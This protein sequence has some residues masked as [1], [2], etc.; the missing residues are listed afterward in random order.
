MEG[1]EYDGLTGVTLTQVGYSGGASSD[2]TYYRLGDHTEVV[3]ITFC[4]HITSL[5]ALLSHFWSWHDS[6]VRRSSQYKSL[7]VC[8]SQDQLNT[9]IA[10]QAERSRSAQRRSLTSIR[11]GQTFHL[12]EEKHQKYYFK[13]DPALVRCLAWETSP[14]TSYLITRLNG[15]LGGRASVAAFNRE[16]EALGLSRKIAEYV[17]GII[18]GRC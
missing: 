15:Y 1:G 18:V 5:S 7:I 4:P 16:W 14:A 6:S 10:L 2:P 17:R 8:S 13:R 11:T 12:A 9:A 3:S